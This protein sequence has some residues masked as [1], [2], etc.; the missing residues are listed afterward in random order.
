MKMTQRKKHLE[1]GLCRPK[2]HKGK[3]SLHGANRTKLLLVS[4]RKTGKGKT[5]QGNPKE[6]NQKLET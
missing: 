2:N 3:Y 6:L 5:I 1:I 4:F